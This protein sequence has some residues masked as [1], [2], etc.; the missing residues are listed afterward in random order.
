[1]ICELKSRFLKV[2]VKV[3]GFVFFTEFSLVLLIGR[4]VEWMNERG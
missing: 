2:G 3:D 1:M 4:F